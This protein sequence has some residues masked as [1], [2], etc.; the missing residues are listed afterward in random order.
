MN[1]NI[2]FPYFEGLYL[3]MTTITLSTVLDNTISKSYT[4][5]LIKNDTELY[6]RALQANY[7]NLLLLSPIYYVFVYNYFLDLT[8]TQTFYIIDYSLLVV[9]HNIGYYMLHKMMHKVKYLK[10][11]HDFHHMFKKTIATVGNAVEPSEFNIAYVIPFI[12][13]SLLVQPNNF[14]FK[15]A[16]MTISLLNL[17]IHCPNFKD[18]N[19][20]KFLVSP[21]QHMK[22]HENYSGTYAAPLLNIDYFLNTKK[23]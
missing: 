2:F 4:K 15:C 7:I 11:M 14:T 22:H 8:K 1:V 20:P 6:I 9:I 3:G 23:D 5:D 16:I 21:G 18:L 13:G 10:Y 19:M 17:F 12:V